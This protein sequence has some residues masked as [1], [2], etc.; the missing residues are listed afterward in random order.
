VTGFV[1]NLVDRRVELTAEGFADDLKGYLAALS[2]RMSG[3]IRHVDCDSR[4]AIGEFVN[5]DIRY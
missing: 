3:H 1:R 2:E 4:P 5:F